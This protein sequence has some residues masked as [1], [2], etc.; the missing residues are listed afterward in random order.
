MTRQKI[1]GWGMLAGLLVAGITTLAGWIILRTVDIPKFTLVQFGT[2][3]GIAA[4]TI[5]L[6]VFMIGYRQSTERL[7]QYGRL[8]KLRQF[9]ISLSLAFVHSAIVFLF[10]VAISNIASNYVSGVEFDDGTTLTSI[11][12]V[13]ALSAYTALVMSAS[14]TA[15]KIVGTLMAFIVAGVLTSMITAGDS[16]WWTHHFSAL[17]AGGTASSYAFN[18]TMILGGIVVASLADYIVTDLHQ[19]YTLDSKHIL[20]R[21]NFLRWGF[22]G[23]G[24]SMLGIAL[25]PYDEFLTIHNIFGYGMSMIFAVLIMILPW[26]VPIFPRI[27]YVVSYIFIG[28]AGF[29]YFY[30]WKGVGSIS[31]IIAEMIAVLLFFVW[32]V[33]FVRQINAVYSDEEHFVSQSG[34]RIAVKGENNK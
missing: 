8:R 24:I 18:L 9:L 12:A 26:I 33:L 30:L 5:V 17:G 31:F 2:V 20:K 27:F 32:L 23:V 29:S 19:I 15:S 22:I 7:I 13:S 16:L 14:M 28:L 25:F 4:A 11:A 10:M 1:E 34:Y 3:L 6:I 21:M